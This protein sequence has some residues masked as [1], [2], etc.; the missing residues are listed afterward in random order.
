MYQI[1][2]DPDDFQ[3]Y[4]DSK[5]QKLLSSHKIRVIEI[6]PMGYYF[7]VLADILF[8]GIKKIENKFLREFLMATFYAFNPLLAKLDNRVKK[9]NYRAFTTGFFVVGEK[10]DFD[11]LRC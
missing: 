2:L 9:E 1:H 4:T 6:K 8:N 11:S 10:R 3:R 5:L 7:S